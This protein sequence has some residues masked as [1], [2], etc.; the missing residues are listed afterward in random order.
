MK[1]YI[2]QIQRIKKKL[3][4][5]KNIDKE[6]R[7]FGAN[8]HKYIINDPSTE[9]EISEIETK[10]SIKLPNSYKSFILKIGNG[11]QS[12]LSSAAGPDYGI[13][14]LGVNCNE[15]ILEETELYLKNSCIISPDM[16]DE[17][18]NELVRPIL[19]MEN[20]CTE[21]KYK[22]QEGYVF[23]GILPISSKGCS[24]LSGLILNGKYKGRVIFLDYD[25]QKPLFAKD[26][27]F[28]DWYES[29]LDKIISREL[30]PNE[31]ERKS[32]KWYEIWK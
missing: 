13:Y 16:T 8:S 11:G 24:Y 7:V 12:Y 9:R 22:K 18:W 19:R 6:H 17:Y 2:E 10:Y 15:L 29:W 3:I 30:L 25:L 4:C 32:K 26:E 5:A 28:L 14:P 31:K 27:N 20:N 21:E 23:G 1:D